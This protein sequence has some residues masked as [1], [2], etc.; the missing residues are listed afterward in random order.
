MWVIGKEKK[1]GIKHVHCGRLKILIK[2]D[3]SAVC[4]DAVTDN[5]FG[6]SLVCERE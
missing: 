4:G 3:E 5:I 1:E 2:L 6:Y